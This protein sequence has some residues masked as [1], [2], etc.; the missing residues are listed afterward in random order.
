MHLSIHIFFRHVEWCLPPSDPG[1]RTDLV[2]SGLSHSKIPKTHCI[3]TSRKGRKGGGGGRERKKKERK[4]EKRKK[5]RGGDKWGE[6]MDYGLCHFSFPPPLSFLSFLPFLPF[7]PCHVMSCHVMSCH[8][9]SCHVMSCHVMSCHV[10]PCHA[11]PC[12]AM[13]CH[14]PHPTDL[15]F[16]LD[17][18]LDVIVESHL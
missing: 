1:W 18:V 11:M 12:H 6:I 9:M 15:F 5:K 2:L 8:V 17:N 16:V 7:L 13:P 14:V 4:K 10:M 3:P